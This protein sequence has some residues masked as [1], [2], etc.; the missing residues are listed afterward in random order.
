MNFSTPA[1]ADIHVTHA[2]HQASQIR[3][4]RPLNF[5]KKCLDFMPQHCADICQKIKNKKQSGWTTALR[6]A[7]Q[8]LN[9]HYG[10]DLQFSLWRTQLQFVQSEY[11]TKKYN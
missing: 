4:G 8:M 5:D 9:M 1:L 6:K 7:L 2:K 10:W 11:L 3:K